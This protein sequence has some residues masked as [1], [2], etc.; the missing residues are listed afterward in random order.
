VAHFGRYKVAFD[1]FRMAL[2][3]AQKTTRYL[4]NLL[5]I[6]PPP[7]RVTPPPQL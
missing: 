6:V 3:P 5:F 1:L 7:G 2:T 4:Y